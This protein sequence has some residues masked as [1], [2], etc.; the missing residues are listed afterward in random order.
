MASA[1][2]YQNTAAWEEKLQNIV[3][4]VKR[5]L[6]SHAIKERVDHFMVYFWQQ[7][8]VNLRK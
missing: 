2:P 7:D 5:D 1:D 4:A 6:T 8:N 3:C